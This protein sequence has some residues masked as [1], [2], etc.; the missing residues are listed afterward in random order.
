MLVGVAMVKNMP[1]NY[2]TLS[3]LGKGHIASAWFYP[4]IAEL[5]RLQVGGCSCA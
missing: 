5:E 2:L 4:E 1:T 3:L